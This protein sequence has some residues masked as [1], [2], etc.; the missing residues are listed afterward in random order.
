M[1]WVERIEFRRHARVPIINLTHKSGVECDVSLDMSEVNTSK[2]IQLFKEKCGTSVLFILSAFL[3]IY[4]Y[5]LDIDKPFS[6]T[7]IL[8]FQVQYYYL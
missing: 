1:Q 8:L 5:Q 7:I 6:G 3:K 2:V 4:L